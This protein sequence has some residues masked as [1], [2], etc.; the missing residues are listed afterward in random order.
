MA[1]STHVKIP[2]HVKTLG[3][4]FCVSALRV[5]EESRVKYVSSTSEPVVSDF[6]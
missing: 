1:K 5:G 3:R 2:V 6:C 4:R